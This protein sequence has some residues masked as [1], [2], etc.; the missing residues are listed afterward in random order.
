MKKR[1][2]HST[3]THSTRPVSIKRELRDANLMV[4]Q[5]SHQIQSQNAKMA[6]L[7]RTLDVWKERNLDLSLEVARREGY[8][9]RVREMDG[10]ARTARTRLSQA[11]SRLAEEDLTAE[12]ILKMSDADFGKLIDKASPALERALGRDPD[13]DYDD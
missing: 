4:G 6:A 1:R 12:Q 3:S 7:A 10:L 13:E 11:A 9:D 8:I 2:A 5:M